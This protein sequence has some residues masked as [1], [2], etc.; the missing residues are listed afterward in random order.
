MFLEPEWGRP[1]FTPALISS[2][3]GFSPGG[4]NGD[5]E[6]FTGLHTCD[7]VY[8]RGPTAISVDAEYKCLIA[9]FDGS[10]FHE[11]K[12]TK[13][14]STA[15]RLRAHSFCLYFFSATPSLVQLEGVGSVGSRRC[16]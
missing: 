15:Q 4:E 7:R 12:K 2:E 8:L 13:I 16:A 5:L 11:P 14:D 6:K 1:I 3:D 10:L 9:Q